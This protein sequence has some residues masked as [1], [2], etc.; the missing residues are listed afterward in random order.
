[1]RNDITTLFD[2]LTPYSLGFDKMFERLENFKLPSLNGMNYPPFNVKKVDDNHF[3]VEMAVAGFG[4]NDLDITM[5]NGTLIISGKSTIDTED[6]KYLFKGIA[7]RAF[8]RA[9]TLADTIEIKDAKILNG[10]LRVYLENMIP[11]SKQAKKIPITNGDASEEKDTRPP[12][13]LLNEKAE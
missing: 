6:D 8:S 4:Q 12:T 3:V 1:M 7:T 11:L 13:R 2:S 10:M 5:E 9:F